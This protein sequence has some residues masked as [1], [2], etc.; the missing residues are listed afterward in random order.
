[1]AFNE[2]LTVKD[3]GSSTPVGVQVSVMGA[4]L[5]GSV[6]ENPWVR[7]KVLSCGTESETASTVSV[8]GLEVV[9]EKFGSSL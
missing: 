3:S 1:M 4:G 2:Q 5:K 6:F 9:G 7:V 8:R